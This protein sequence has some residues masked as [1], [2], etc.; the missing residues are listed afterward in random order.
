M[1]RVESSNTA[2]ETKFEVTIFITEY[3]S[4]SSWT[5][6][7]KERPSILRH[8]KSS[9]KGSQGFELAA[10]GLWGSDSTNRARLPN[11]CIMLINLIEEPWIVRSLFSTEL[12]L[13]EV[14]LLNF[15]SCMYALRSGSLLRIFKV[16]TAPSLTFR[17]TSHSW[18]HGEQPL[19]FCNCG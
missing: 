2:I 11:E 15:R 7:P 1:E 8:T 6:F 12:G 5:K 10:G 17:K 16:Q 18:G 19:S 13:L 4:K 9:S 14:D 3:A